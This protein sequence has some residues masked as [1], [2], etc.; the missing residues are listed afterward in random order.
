MRD[1]L[2]AVRFL[3]GLSWRT[4][5]R[6]LLVGGG[7][8]MLGF[9][10]T[11]LIAVA[12]K[13]L[14]DAALAGDARTA[15]FWAVVAG[16]ALIA[17]LQAGH[18]GH[19]SY[20]ELGETNENRL[21]R[22]ILH[23]VNGTDRLDRCDDPD[24][25][26]ALTL[27]RQ[28]VMRMRECV[29]AVLQL[30]GLLVQALI[31]AVILARLQ[32][33]LLLL[34]LVAVV[35]V[36]AGKRAERVLQAGREQAS[37]L[38]RQIAHLREL[39][40]TPQTQKEIRISGSQAF[41]V[42]AQSRLQWELNVVLGRALRRHG[43]LRAAGQTVFALAY[44]TS[45]VLVIRMVDRGSAGP[46]DVVL[47]VTLATQVSTQVTTGLELLA[48]LHTA[49]SGFR[50]LVQLR[51]EAS[52]PVQRPGLDVTSLRQGITL[53]GVGF[54][55]PASDAEVLREVDLHLPAGTS[56]ALVGENGAGKSTLIKL[57]T[58]LYVPTSGR[59]LVDGT[60]LAGV[61][62]GSWRE[63]TA[64]LFQ[65]FAHLD[66]TVQDSVGVGRLADVA[67][68]DAVRAAFGRARA[69]G[70]LESLPDGL[71]TLLGSGYGEG[72]DLSGGQWQGV[73]FSRTLMRTDPL[74]LSLD[75]PGHALDALAEER[76]CEAYYA[77]AREFAV[78]LGGVTLF[79]TH[80]LSTV[81]LADLIVV[82][83]EGRVVEVGS[84]DELLAAD[85]R[86]A[87]LFTLQSR[88]YA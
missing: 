88:A 37:P 79:V 6:R 11:P 13:G 63:R 22:E 19:L 78:T 5:R 64:T 26:D 60:D 35:P 55:Y 57:L 86:Y 39:A 34:P 75:E 3:V 20:F 82:L 71:D 10:A 9:V 4:D 58:G 28:D 73:G 33:L 65:D 49:A 14:V 85:G 40:T 32:G 62:P 15:S 2:F 27:L 31:T 25:A 36:L 80:R 16:T 18:F 41:L 56:V 24:F 7:L 21:N 84:H 46:G 61:D 54:R 12:L 45:V 42:E 74:L 83:H 50:R 70:V 48:S 76:M 67:D 8:V 52:A 87:E 43:L 47:L 1:L 38:M 69:G 72:R 23:L 81:R 44:I 30:A 51:A 29:S 53:E 77:A 59:I 66:F 17:E 68:P